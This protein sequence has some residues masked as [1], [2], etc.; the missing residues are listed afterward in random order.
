MI[1][2]VSVGMSQL[3]HYYTIFVLLL[4]CYNP[5]AVFQNCVSLQNDSGGEGE[6]GVASRRD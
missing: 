5:C 4:F 1:L 6:H 3:A 2:S